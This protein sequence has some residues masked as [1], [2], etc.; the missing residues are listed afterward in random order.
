MII[1]FDGGVFKESRCYLF[2]SS[3]VSAWKIRGCQAMMGR[4]VFNTIRQKFEPLF[5][6]SSLSLPFSFYP[7]LLL[8]S[9]ELL[10]QE[11]GLDDVTKEALVR[12][13]DDQPEVCSVRCIVGCIHSIHGH[14]HWAC[15]R[16]A[17]NNAVCSVSPLKSAVG[18][19]VGCGVALAG[20]HLKLDDGKPE[21]LFFVPGIAFTF[22]ALR[23]AFKFQSLTP[24]L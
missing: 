6:L 24:W 5:S 21:L 17:R 20:R 23:K 2:I 3:S 16:I 22:S 13:N 11:H 12:R 8:I 10:Y 18:N 4:C 19:A 15:A 1:E 14:P 7:S 9:S